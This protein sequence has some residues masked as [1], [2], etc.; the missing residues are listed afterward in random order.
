[1]LL[2]VSTATTRLVPGFASSDIVSQR[3]SRPT[4]TADGSREGLLSLRL[5]PAEYDW[6]V[7]ILLGLGTEARALAPDDLRPRVLEAA[8]ELAAHYAE[9]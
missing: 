2:L 1:M 5:R 4:S 9:R 3:S 8:R 6:L 7:R